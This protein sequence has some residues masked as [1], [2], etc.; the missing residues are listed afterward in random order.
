[1]TLHVDDRRRDVHRLGMEQPLAKCPEVPADELA[2]ALVPGRV[3][4]TDGYRLGRG[5]GH[6][7]RLLPMVPDEVPVIGATTRARL[8]ARLPREPHDR[9]MSHLAI[10]TGVYPAT[11]I[12]LRAAIG[13]AE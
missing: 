10:E 12:Q 7:D 4:D 1:M 9:P 2:A 11:S 8:V 3:F 6:Y 13:R 5:G